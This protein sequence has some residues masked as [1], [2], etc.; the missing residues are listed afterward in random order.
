V[1][2]LFS[3][4]LTVTFLGGLPSGATAPRWAL[5]S[6]VVT[7]T[8]LWK[9][10]PQ[11]AWGALLLP[12]VYFAPD[13]YGAMLNGWIWLLWLGVFFIGRDANLRPV[14]IGAALGFWVN[15]VVVVAQYFGWQGIPHISDL[16]GLFLNR[17]TG[18]E[19]AA[20]VLAYVAFEKIW[21]VVPGLLPSLL[22]GGRA[23]I[24]A[25]GTAFFVF[26]WRRSR[27]QAMVGMLFAALLLAV[28]SSSNPAWWSSVIERRDLWQDV[29]ASMTFFGHGFGSFDRLFPLYQEHTDALRIRFD[30]PHN[31]FLLLAWEFG[32]AGVVLAG[33][34][35]WRMARVVPDAAW[36]VVLVLSIEA[37]FEFPFHMPVSGFLGALCFGALCH[38]RVRVRGQLPDGGL[39]LRAGHAHSRRFGFPARA[40][41]VSADALAPHGPGL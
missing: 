1:N 38:G 12:L 11:V 25:L 5:L 40:A 37:C 9:P 18:V 29:V 32:L 17:N 13:P 7:L 34:F 26:T 10:Y 20:M 28:L 22:A 24:L 6:V 39:V 31:E 23:P 3:F 35:A 21:W 41:P 19:A 30:H 36:Y 14:F 16:S 27:F 15:S 4:L 2:G 8:C 33:C